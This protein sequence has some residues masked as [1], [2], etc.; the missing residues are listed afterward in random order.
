MHPGALIAVACG[1]IYLALR[2]ALFDFDGYT[3][4]MYASQPEPFYNVN[5]HHL[6]WNTIQIALVGVTSAL[7]HSSE[8]PFQIVGILLNCVTLF[9]FYL[10]LFSVSGSRVFAVMADILVAFLP[11][12]WYLGFQNQPYPFLFLLVVVYLW[13]WKTPDGGA[14]DRWGL[15]AAGAALILAIL[16]QQALIALVPAATIVLLAH[17]AGRFSS[18]LVRSVVWSA[19]VI[20]VTLATYLAF[21]RAIGITDAKRFFLWTT[22]YAHSI[23]PFRFDF[24]TSLVKAAMGISNA[25]VQMEKIIP[26]LQDRLSAAAIYALY[27]TVGLLACIALMLVIWKVRLGSRLAWL[28]RQDA[29]FAV[30][31]LSIVLWSAFVL[32][33]EPANDKFWLLN[34]FP[35]LVCLGTLLRDRVNMRLV[36]ITG[37]LVVLLSGWNAYF[38]YDYDRLQSKNDPERLLAYLH[39]EIGSRD[40]FITLGRDDG[41]GDMD[42]ELLFTALDNVHSRAGIAI[43]DFVGFE[44]GVLR[45]EK[46]RVR[47]DSSLGFGGRVFVAAHVFDRASYPS[48]SVDPFS[49][50]IQ[51]PPSAARGAVLFEGVRRLFEHYRLGRSTFKIGSEGYYSVCPR[52]VTELSHRRSRPTDPAESVPCRGGP[53]TR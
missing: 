20:G 35:G 27:G 6:L 31:L 16:L 28:A 49:K 47:I 45:A 30:S 18:R 51:T 53:V 21:A 10:L 15:I 12:F 39:R 25:L 5:A 38:D 32:V 40:I 11:Q 46:L 52:Q 44:T 4:R 24:P 29:L 48:G 17:G 3:F 14:P 41:L 22:G 36:W 23:H 8:I 1:A 19:G 43:S 34:V 50:W 33:W 2:P 37:T 7:F 26:I 42:Y 13:A 9:V